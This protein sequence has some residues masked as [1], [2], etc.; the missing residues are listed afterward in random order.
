MNGQ[1]FNDEHTPVT[2]VGQQQEWRRMKS[3]GD[4][5]GEGTIIFEFRNGVV[6]YAPFERGE[7]LRT[8]VWWD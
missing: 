4:G 7:M 5:W 8:K 2:W 3:P 6:K 1:L